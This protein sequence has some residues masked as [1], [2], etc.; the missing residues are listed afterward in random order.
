MGWPSKPAIDTAFFLMRVIPVMLLC[1]GLYA[2]G[3]NNGKVL[4]VSQVNMLGNRHD[5][6]YKGDTLT[7]IIYSTFI[8]KSDTDSSKIDTL[9]RKDIDSL[10]YES[11]KSVSMFRTFSRHGT[12]GKIHRR[13]RFNM[14]NLLSTISRFNGKTEYT[15]DSVIYDYTSKKAYY[16]DLI[17]KV[18]EVIEYDRDNNITTI[19]EEKASANFFIFAK[20]SSQPM[21]NPIAEPLRVTYNYFS[22]TNDPFLINLDDSELLFGCFNRKSVGLFWSG[23]HRPEFRSVNNVQAVK[24]SRHGTETNALYEYQM[25]DGLPTA[26]Y[27]GYGVVY[28]R[29]R[30]LH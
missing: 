29:Y 18:V 14:D 17:N 1:L 22:K 5:L 9:I 11:D 19:T 20:P 4:I 13:F 21:L 6:T 16:Y 3:D 7:R 24:E 23:G 15:T 26:R 25:E 27:G 30:R 12:Y 2:C 8:T 10:I 28:Y